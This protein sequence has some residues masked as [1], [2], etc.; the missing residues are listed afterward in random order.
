MA[1]PEAAPEE[2]G[3]GGEES[4]AT[5]EAP[6]EEAP[7]TGAETTEFMGGQIPRAQVQELAQSQGKVRTLVNSPVLARETEQV[8]V[9]IGNME[10]YPIHYF[11]EMELEVQI[12]GIWYQVPRKAAAQ[13]EEMVTLEP[14]MAKDE[15]FLFADY[16]LDYEA[17]QYRIVTYFDDLTLCSDFRFETL[18]EGLSEALDTEHQ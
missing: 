9:T 7:D 16:E 18:E 13:N 12:G 10:E 5:E 6:A 14:G 2:A 11:A 1:A 17:E 15:S 3:A 4:A 8:T